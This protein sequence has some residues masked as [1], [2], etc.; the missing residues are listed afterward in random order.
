MEYDHIFPLAHQRVA[1]KEKMK[2][3]DVKSCLRVDHAGE[4]A[5]T[6][7]YEGQLSILSRSSVASTIKE[8]HRQE[9]QHLSLFE[10]A[11]KTT[12]TPPSLL[13]PFWEKAAFGLGVTTA[14]MGK[15]AAMACTIAV[16]EVIEQHYKSQIDSLPTTTPSEIKKVIESCYLDEISHKE[17]AEDHD[18][19][20]TK[21]YKTLST[22][23]KTG[24][25]AAIWL[26][27]RI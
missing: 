11:L 21:G 4:L 9:T 1:F 27:K 18:G 7:I 6:K 13:N 3:S 26:S 15:K 14:L 19:R 2:K 17:K 5:A 25:R 10:N 12:E 23:I 24:C 8:M 16:E 22:A 20:E